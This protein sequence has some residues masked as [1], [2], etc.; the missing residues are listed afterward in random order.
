MQKIILKFINTLIAPLNILMIPSKY[1]SKAMRLIQRMTFS[2]LSKETIHLNEQMSLHIETWK[3]K[4]SGEKVATSMWSDKK[5]KKQIKLPHFRSDNKYLYQTRDNNTPDSV[6]LTY[7]YIKMNDRLNI[8]GRSNENGEF[9][10]D[11]IKIPTFGVISRD[12]LDSANELNFLEKIFQVSKIRNL[13]IFD[14]GAGYGRLALHSIINLKNIKKYV[15]LDAVPES[16]GLCE[17][18]LNYKN[19][20]PEKYQVS[21][22]PVNYAPPER[23]IAV[24]IH[25]F[26]EMPM[27]SVQSWIQFLKEMGTSWLLIVPNRENHNG[28]ELLATEADCTRTD[29]SKLLYEYGFERQGVFPKYEDP[30]IQIYGVSPTMYHLYKRSVEKETKLQ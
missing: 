1:N 20:N 8:L 15:C 5:L 3:K 7:K 11:V 16:L 18:Y 22:L 23:S 2:K 28:Q 19:I 29:Y 10:A 24:A 9:G 17:F 21:T 30:D 14:I 25:S 12:L 27:A 13:T 4:T 26:S 6:V